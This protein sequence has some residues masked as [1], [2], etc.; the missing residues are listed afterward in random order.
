M[1]NRILQEPSIIDVQSTANDMECFSN[2]KDSQTWKETPKTPT[3]SIWY[4]KP[5]N[6]KHTS[7]ARKIT[8]VFITHSKHHQNT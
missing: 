1:W 3:T 7:T 5:T 8:K 6:W 2:S 4:N